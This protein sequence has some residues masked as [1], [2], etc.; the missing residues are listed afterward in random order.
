MSP[1]TKENHIVVEVMRKEIE[2]LE[3]SEPKPADFVKPESKLV[4]VSLEEGKHNAP[5]VKSEIPSG[6]AKLSI[7][8]D[9]EF[10]PR[11]LLQSQRDEKVEPN[12]SISVIPNGPDSPRQPDPIVQAPNQE[13]G[14]GLQQ[15]NNGHP[16]DLS[17]ILNNHEAV[18]EAE[19]RARD[20]IRAGI[21]LWQ[22][23]MGHGS[24]EPT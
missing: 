2:F 13:A 23:A 10:S 14:A 7:P 11:E 5:N 9:E 6:D 18:Q 12:D 17:E 19:A 1:R 20:R 15:G 4:D 16:G 22:Y 21:S 8:E 3:S 24:V